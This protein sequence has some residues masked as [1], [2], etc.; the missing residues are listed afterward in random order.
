MNIE[1]ELY[2]F[3]KNI[4]PVELANI[5]GKRQETSTRDKERLLKKVEEIDE[6]LK[7]LNVKF[8]LDK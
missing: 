7:K 3:F 1:S 4:T 2:N 6:I 5:R 8:S